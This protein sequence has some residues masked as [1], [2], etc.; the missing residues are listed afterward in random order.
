M[1]QTVSQHLVSD[2]P[3]GL[4][5][6][7]GLDSSSLAYYMSQVEEMEVESFSIDFQEDSYGESKYASKVAKHLSCNHH[8]TMV[9]SN[10]I[11]LL[12]KLVWHSEEP[13][14]DSSMLAYY[15][16]CESARKKITVAIGGD[17]ADE[18]LAGYETYSAWKAHQMYRCLPS[19]LTSTVL[20]PMLNQ[21]SVSDKKMSKRF[22]L[23]RFLNTSEMTSEEAHASWRVIFDEEARSKLLQPLSQHDGIHSDFRTLFIDSFNNSPAT[24][25]VNRMLYVDSKVYLPSD[26]LTKVDRMSMAHSL[27]VRVPF[28]DHELVDF[29]NTVPSK[30]KLKYWL[31]KKHLLKQAMRGRL[32][33]DIIYRKKAGFNL[34]VNQ[35]LRSGMKEF[36]CD[37]LSESTIKT[38]GIFDSDYVAS[39]L[40]NHFDKKSDNSFEIWG[41]LVCSIWF[42]TFNPRV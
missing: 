25:P 27:E 42:S 20:K 10:A 38:M 6:S 16:L 40:Q 41:L 7:G 39:L 37:H 14:A 21:F 13:T 11:E 2:V 3:H 15:H 19:W 22:K 1:R 18:I 29:V 23:R 12:P 33:N 32:T 31:K 8:S 9:E 34:P 5:L 36:V 35:W 26:M 24:D 28:L 17:G 4:L 30:Y